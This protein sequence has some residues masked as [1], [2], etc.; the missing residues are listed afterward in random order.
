MINPFSCFRW[1]HSGRFFAKSAQ[2][3][4]ITLPSLA[5]RSNPFPESAG[6]RS[7]LTNLEATSP[8]VVQPGE[9]A[10]SCLLAS[11]P[12]RCLFQ[13]DTVEAWLIG[14]QSTTPPVQTIF[15]AALLLTVTFGAVDVVFGETTRHM[16]SGQS[17]LVPAATALTLKP[18]EEAD[19]MMLLTDDR[20][21]RAPEY[22]PGA[23]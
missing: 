1:F 8:G 22:N 16:V 2:A 21:L 23:S 5:E 9:V 7:G 13:S 20:E 3:S 19:V 4:W 15:K 14:L 10:T 12:H 18:H 17:L 11:C 6:D